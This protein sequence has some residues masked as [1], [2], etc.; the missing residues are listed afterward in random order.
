MT[1]S[2]SVKR[3]SSDAGCGKNPPKENREGLDGP[4]KE[5]L[6]KL[7]PEAMEARVKAFLKAAYENLKN[8]KYFVSKEEKVSD[9]K[10]SFFLCSIHLEVYLLFPLV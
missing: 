7:S 4:P 10:H 6:V 5:K 2:A 9:G 1:R 8:F 3:K